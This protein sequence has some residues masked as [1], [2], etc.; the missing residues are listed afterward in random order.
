MFF[1][2]SLAKKANK[3]T[4]ISRHPNPTDTSDISLGP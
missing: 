4:P 2:K 3:K 1:E